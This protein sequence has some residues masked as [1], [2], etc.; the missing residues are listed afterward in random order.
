MRWLS[1]VT[2]TS[3]WAS[4]I[5]TACLLVGCLSTASATGEDRSGLHNLVSANEDARMD[6]QD[7]AFFLVTHN[8][9]AKPK[10]GYVEVKLQGKICKLIPNGDRPGLCEKKF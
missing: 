9:D 8:Y 4:V 7:L 6:C 2:Q 10:D 3:K 5:T 1:V